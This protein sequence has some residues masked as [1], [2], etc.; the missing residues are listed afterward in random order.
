M[1]EVVWSESI[2]INKDTFEVVSLRVKLLRSHYILLTKYLVPVWDPHR[3]QTIHSLTEDVLCIFQVSLQ[4]GWLHWK[5]LMNLVGSVL[6]LSI[7]LYAEY[8]WMEIW[9]YAWRAKRIVLFPRWMTIIIL[10]ECFWGVIK[11]IEH[12][13]NH[14]HFCCCN[15]FHFKRKR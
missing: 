7:A 8:I 14:F 5:L 1:V 2:R 3:R 9:C 10:V 15:A 13:V 4:F 11:L 12:P 6:L